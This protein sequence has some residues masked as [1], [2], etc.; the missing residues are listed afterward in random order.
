MA[1]IPRAWREC[2]RACTCAE[3]TCIRGR[4]VVMLGN[5]VLENVA[6]EIVVLDVIAFDISGSRCSVVSNAGR[7]IGIV[8]AFFMASD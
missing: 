8:N 5:V 6:L 3:A 4:F 1:E 7:A 2:S